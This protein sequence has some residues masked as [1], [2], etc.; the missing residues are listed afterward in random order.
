M[1]KE[2]KSELEKHVAWNEYTWNLVK[3]FEPTFRRA[4]ILSRVHYFISQ[5][6]PQ[7]GRLWALIEQS[8]RVQGRKGLEVLAK[9]MKYYNWDSEKFATGIKELIQLHGADADDLDQ[10][11]QTLINKKTAE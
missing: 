10:A 3:N 6:C 1:N 11:V 8:K 4:G 9:L 7:D 2:E 5:G